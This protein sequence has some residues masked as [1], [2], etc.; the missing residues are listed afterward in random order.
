[1][2]LN[3]KIN[4]YK[5]KHVLV[6]NGLKKLQTSDSSY[7]WGKIHFVDSDGTQNYF[8][9]QPMFRYFKKTDNTD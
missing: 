6:K 7:F 3:R 9:F 5:R 4:S 2:R 1:M 8:V